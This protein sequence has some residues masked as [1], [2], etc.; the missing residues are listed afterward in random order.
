MDA[1]SRMPTQFLVLALVVAGVLLLFGWVTVETQNTSRATADLAARNTILIE[2]VRVLAEKNTILLAQV[3]VLAQQGVI[4]HEGLCTYVH[5]LKLRLEGSKQ[6]LKDHPR[7]SSV[8]PVTLL[9]N[10]IKAQTATLNSLKQ[11]RCHTK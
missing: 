8:I 11:Q 5:D 10:S 7:G 2:Q 1:N 3:K 6:Y 9:R 4:A